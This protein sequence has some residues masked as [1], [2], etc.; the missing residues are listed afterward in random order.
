MIGREFGGSVVVRAHSP[1][2]YVCRCACGKEFM[3][4]ED[5]LVSGRATECRYCR[6][7]AKAR[8]RR[9]EQ[10]DALV[11]RVIGSWTILC[12]DE[13]KFRPNGS[14]YVFARC[15]CGA[16][17][18]VSVED[19]MDGKSSSCV[20][21]ARRRIVG[22]NYARRR[23]LSGQVFGNWRALRMDDEP[24]FDAHGRPDVYYICEC[25][26]CGS[27][28]SI[29][30]CFLRDENRVIVCHACGSG[31]EASNGACP[32]R[33]AMERHVLRFFGD[34]TDL[35]DRVTFDDLTGLGGKAL[36][37]D[38]GV[39]LDDEPVCLI[40]CQ[41][42][43]H[44]E[45]V[46]AFGGD[47]SFQRQLVHDARKR[48]YAIRHGLPLIEIPYTCDTYEKV[49]DFLFVR[50]FVFEGAFSCSKCT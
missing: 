46:D 11:G 27:R 16:I 7:K 18:S 40:E 44:Y 38:F 47:D 13:G 4:T 21:C 34:G 6:G 50:S 43:Q 23:D 19:L 39:Y 30:A 17:H 49:S 29:R 37:Y 31:V 12:A 42:R 20:D 48:H 25:V 5:D 33:P 41:G 26:E 10:R 32:G 22:R 45:P 1:S 35:R 36:S 15:E 28:K 2:K 9:M 14:G 8:K 24:H 3:A